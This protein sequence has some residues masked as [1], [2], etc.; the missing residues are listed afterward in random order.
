MA[1]RAHREIWADYDERS[2]V[3]YQA[4]NDAIADAALTA[5]TF[6][7]PF[8]F[9]RMTWIKPSYRID[10]ARRLL[11]TERPY[12]LAANLAAAIGAHSPLPG[13]A[14]PGQAL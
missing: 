6:V 11:P 8:S 3:V 13:Q 1:T 10:A 7:A 14:R 4:Y 9:N 2:I 12:P 5:G